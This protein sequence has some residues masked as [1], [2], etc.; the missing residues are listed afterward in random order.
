MMQEQSELARVDAM[1]LTLEA[2]IATRRDIQRLDRRPY[3][4][5]GLRR[6]E[7]RC[8]VLETMLDLLMK[9]KS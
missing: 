9:G 4:S 5:R 8:R 7:W 6:L 3:R 2:L 1:L